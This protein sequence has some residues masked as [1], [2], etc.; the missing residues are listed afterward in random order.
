[1]QYDYV[2]RKY[3][4]VV[5]TTLRFPYVILCLNLMTVCTVQYIYKELIRRSSSV[6]KENKVPH[7]YKELIRRI[8][9]FEYEKLLLL[10]STQDKLASNFVITKR[11]KASKTYHIWQEDINIKLL[12][13]QTSQ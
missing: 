9:T 3:C 4:F 2:V 5:F 1:M 11:N 8:I 12:I 6:N 10:K 13:L 7:I